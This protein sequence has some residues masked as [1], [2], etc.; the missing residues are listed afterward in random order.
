MLK[1]YCAT[2]QVQ[3]KQSFSNEE[4]ARLAKLGRRLGRKALADI[5]C[6]VKRDTILKCFRDLVA[7]KF[8][9]SKNR[10]CPGRPKVDPEIEKLVLQFADENAN[11]GHGRGGY[12][13]L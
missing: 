3:V 13:A 2:P 6:I 7:K 10:S 12:N 5:G 11:K 8:D 1:F 4:R 9:G